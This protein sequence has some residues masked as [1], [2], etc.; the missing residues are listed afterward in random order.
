M[1]RACKEVE[2]AVR[3]SNVPGALGKVLSALSTQNINILAY[4]SYSDRLETVVLLVA[5]DPFR[6]KL[7]LEAAGFKCKANPVVLVGAPEHI[8]AAAEVGA[9]LGKAGIDILYSYA[10]STGT[11]DFYAVFK[12]ADDDRAI[13]LLESDT[14]RQ[15]IWHAA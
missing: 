6:A 4:C 5:Q 15:S 14:I 1:I 8:G 11:G 13:H 12:T 2:L 3:V 7:A 9:H 10:S